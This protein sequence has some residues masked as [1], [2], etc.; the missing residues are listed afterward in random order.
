MISIKQFLDTRR[1]SAPPK[2]D[3]VDALMQMGRLILDA[4][5]AYMVRGTDADLEDFRRKL[6]R[7]V[8]QMDTPQSPMSVLGIT[9]DAVEALETYGERTAKYNREQREERQS[10]VAMLTDT[11]AELAGQSDAAVSRL[12]SIEK[13]LGRASELDDIR[14]LKTSLGESLRA[15]REAAAHHRST[16]ATT[17]ERLRAQLALA[18]ARV[19]DVPEPPAYNRDDIDS[20]PEPSAIPVESRSVSYVAAIRLRRADHIATRFGESVRLRMLTM[21]GTQLKGMLSADDRLL[22]WKG[23]SF[24]MF[25]N[26]KESLGQIR[27]RLS[28]VVAMINQQYIE[29]GSKTS[30]LS[31]GVDWV[32]FSQADH[33][34]L[35][36]VFTEVGAFLVNATQNGSPAAVS[37]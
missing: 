19:A 34:T 31:I 37:R 25:L 26:S 8:R 4:V 3:L 23:T 2:N 15:V 9:S 13:D 20:I 30:L 22:R 18:R 14:A 17:M 10:M 7:L 27:G 21:I 33:P 36:A 28:S 24:V 29:V 1:N 16:S 12:Q 35:E 11:V 32:V 6:N 5:A